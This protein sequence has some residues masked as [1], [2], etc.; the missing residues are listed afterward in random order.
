MS[1][2]A[3]CNDSKCPFHGGLKVRGRILEGRVSSLK[4]Q[5]SA[6]IEVDYIVDMKKFQR[7]EK[8]R[9]KIH[10]HVPDCIKLKVGS[11]VEI[12]SCRRLSKTISFVVTKVLKV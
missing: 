9:R 3:D 2:K 4:Q 11:L 5:K 12:S 7:F 10:A 6:V 8:R 1:E